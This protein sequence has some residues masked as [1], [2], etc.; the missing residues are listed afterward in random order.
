MEP[1]P[2]IV[3][4]P[5]RLIEAKLREHLEPGRNIRQLF[6]LEVD[7]RMSRRATVATRADRARRPGMSRLQMSTPRK[8]R[9]H[10]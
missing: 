2:P 10:V 9:G 8:G 7:H 4:G 3:V 1:S 6:Q 5:E